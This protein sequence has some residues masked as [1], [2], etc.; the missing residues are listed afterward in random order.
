M[1]RARKNGSAGVDGEAA[2]RL[3]VG[4]YLD[5]DRFA[6]LGLLTAGIAHEI[7]T[8]LTYIN[9]SAELLRRA[10]E[11]IRN[12]MDQAGDC[13]DLD[14]AR[15][16]RF[17]LNMADESIDSVTE[18]SRRIAGM[19]AAMAEFSQHASGR[20]APYYVQ[21]SVRNAL[22][23][24]H[25]SLK[26]HV[27]IE[28]D[29]DETAP[30][31]MAEPQRLDQV[32]VNL[33]KNGADALQQK[34][35]GVIRVTVCGCGQRVR[36][37]VEDSGPGVPA[38]LRDRIWAPFFTTK[39]KGEGLGLGLSVTAAIVADMDGKI[40]VEDRDGGGAR[41]VV[42]IPATGFESVDDDHPERDSRS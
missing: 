40:W 23:L 42:D 7:N 6:K 11:S 17:F 19:V 8:P 39:G 28:T 16:A 22:V 24:C 5:T 20:K 15:R 21:Q 31:V 37:C 36:A 29:L 1:T 4:H 14:L 41:F 34:G 35:A 33:L 9:G 27:S 10:L 18:G 2:V 25:N 32:F 26:Y 13:G 30:Q 38:D 3:P 12:Y